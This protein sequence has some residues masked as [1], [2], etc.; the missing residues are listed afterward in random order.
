MESK[1]RQNSASTYYGSASYS[2]RFVFIGRCRK[3]TTSRYCCSFPFIYKGRRYNSCTKKNHNR[4]WCS[5]TGNYDRDKKWGNCAGKFKILLPP[6]NLSSPY[7]LLF[8]SYILSTENLILNQK[9]F[10]CWHSAILPFSRILNWLLKEINYWSRKIR[11]LQEVFII[12]HLKYF[13]CFTTY[14]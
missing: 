11:A 1:M 9:I 5:L 7:Y 8:V 13:F 2:S 14:L 3:R 10:L 6:K 12:S 4:P